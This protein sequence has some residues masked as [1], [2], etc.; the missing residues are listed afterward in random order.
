MMDELELVRQARPRAVPPTDETRAAARRSLDQAMA[1]PG[2]RRASRPRW[3]S[4]AGL[5]VPALGALVVAA[6]AVAFLGLH[7]QKP[8][9]AGGRT[10]VRFVF[11]ALPGPRQHAVNQAE[12]ERTVV[13]V[14]ARLGASLPGAHVSASGDELIVRTADANLPQVTSLMQGVSRLLFYD[15]EANV[16]TP[17]GSEVA[18]RLQ[19][20]DPAART[21]SQGTASAQP[22]APGAGGLT[23]YNAVRLA[24]RQTR[25]INPSSSRIGPEYFMFGRSGSRACMA[26]ARYYHTNSGRRHCY[27]AGPQPSE[28]VLR[29]ALPPGIRPSAP[30]VRTLVVP[31]GWAVLRATSHR[32]S[33]RRASSDPSAQYYVLRDNVSLTGADLIDVRQSRDETGAPDVTFGFTRRG[34]AEFQT[35]TA[36]IAKRGQLVSGLGQKLFQHFAVALES[37]LDNQ[38]VTVPYIDFNA[39]PDGIPGNNGA[40][41]QAG[42]TTRSARALAA[43]ITPLPVLL[44]VIAVSG[45][46]AR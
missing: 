16:L 21:I 14:R 11:R 38:L 42:F 5:L 20:Q 41:I 36:R 7:T 33:L 35:L 4:G 26:A 39:N 9:G 18:R 31:Q 40:D 46:P 1:S 45:H 25:W 22:G 2:R 17:R 27:L 19:T 15:W 28:P 43:S 10:G 44:K 37:P 24:A 34:G 3:T 12:M 8:G 30:G 6:V 29:H 13:L 32:F 23:L